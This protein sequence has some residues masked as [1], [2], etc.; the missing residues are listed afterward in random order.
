M[1]EI[2]NTHQTDLEDPFL[3]SEGH[4]WLDYYWVGLALT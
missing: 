3:E 1:K 2:A 4:S